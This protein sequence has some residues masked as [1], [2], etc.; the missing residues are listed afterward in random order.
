MQFL[1][2]YVSFY[3]ELQSEIDHMLPVGKET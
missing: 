2:F 1:F 3:P